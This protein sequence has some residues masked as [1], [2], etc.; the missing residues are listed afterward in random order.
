MTLSFGLDP[1]SQVNNVYQDLGVAPPGQPAAQAP[2]APQ[3]Q[4]TQAY[5]PPDPYAQWGGQQAYNNLLSGFHSQKDNIYSSANDLAAQKGTEYKNSILDTVHQ[6][7]LGQ[8]G[9]NAQGVQNEL[10]KRQ[11]T[12]DVYGMVNRGI[13]SGGVMLANKNAG[14]SSA[15]GALA[16]AYGD[17]GRRQM[18]SIGNQYEAGNRDIATKQA[19]QLYQQQSAANKFNDTKTSTVN[20][21]VGS[22]RDQLSALDAQMANASMPERINIEQEKEAIRQSALNQLQQYDRYLTEGLGAIHQN[23]PDE[24]RAQAIQNAQAG[25]A[26]ANSFQ[27]DATVPAQ[28]QGTG[29]FASDLPIFTFPRGRRQA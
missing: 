21:I 18:S 13:K 2:A 11:G 4:Y 3:Q 15:A 7:Q 23:T 6:L 19:E 22:A 24:R 29:P 27:Y 12:Q 10:A 28:W 5:V 9:I 1:V 14:D 25:M 16:G 8:Q 20:S 26:P 17:M